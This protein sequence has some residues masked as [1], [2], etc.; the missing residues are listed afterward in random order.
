MRYSQNLKLVDAP[1]RMETPKA[2]DRK[3]RKVHTKAAKNCWVIL[4]SFAAK[5][6]LCASVTLW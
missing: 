6:L 1:V 3:A 5:R 4:A 2:F